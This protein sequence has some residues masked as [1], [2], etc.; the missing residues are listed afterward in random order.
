MYPALSTVYVLA[1]ECS[2]LAVTGSR[3]V[4]QSCPSFP[5]SGQ[6]T[7]MRHSLAVIALSHKDPSANIMV[8]AR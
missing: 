3:T 4:T 6:S 8:I 1:T 5:F 2:T 7:L